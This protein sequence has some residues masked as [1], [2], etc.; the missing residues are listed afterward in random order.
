VLNLNGSRKCGHD[1]QMAAVV[2][3]FD[4]IGLNPYTAASG[5]SLG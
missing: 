3:K 5:L 4:K 2:R 1:C